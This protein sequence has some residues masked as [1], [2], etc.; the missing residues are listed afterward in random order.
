MGGKLRDIREAASSAVEIIHEMGTPEVR[1][2][3]DK[4]KE[5]TREV[6]EIIE[7]LSTPAMVKNIENLQQMALTMQDAAARMESTVKELKETGIFDEVKKTSEAAR[8]TMDSLGGMGSD[9][10]MKELSKETLLA[11]KQLVEELKLAVADSRRAGVIK[12]A[13]EAAK[14]ISALRETVS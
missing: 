1:D 5:T 13:G 12:N 10:E 11:V 7:A 14:E 2:S 9:G 4:A 8:R 3:L 6:R